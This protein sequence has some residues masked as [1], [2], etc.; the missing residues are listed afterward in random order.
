MVRG[1][2]LHSEHFHDLVAQ[3]V[4]DLDRDAARCWL[5]KGPGDVAVERRPGFRVDLRLEGGL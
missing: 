2:Q 5:V 3:V 1:E 4:D